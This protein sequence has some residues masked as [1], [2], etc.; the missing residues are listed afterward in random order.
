[1]EWLTMG[2]LGDDGK[3]E[4]ARR[5]GARLESRTNRSA[6]PANGSRSRD[7]NRDECGA[8]SIRQCRIRPAEQ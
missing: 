2:W 3:R 4:A 1:M 6:A 7:V 5:R 8:S